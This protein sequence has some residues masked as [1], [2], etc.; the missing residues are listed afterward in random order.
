MKSLSI[1]ACVMAALLAQQAHAQ[2]KNVRMYKCVD[3]DGKVYYSDKLNPDCAKRTEMNRQ[4]VVVEKKELPKTGQPTKMNAP[5]KT[6]LEMERRDKALLASYTNEEEID[7]AR[8]R[9]LVTPIQGMKTIEA[10]LEKANLHLSELKKQ[11][12]ALAS[13]QKKLPDRLLEDVN[14]SQKEIANLE[15]DLAQRKAQSDSIRLKY[16]GEK[17]RFRELKGF[18][19][20]NQ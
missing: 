8:D 11:A 3:T 9:T 2:D 18:E 6:S 20:P 13:Q 12:D 17:K 7:A 10:K 4:G 19:Q 14:A 15:G 1:I 5:T 16:E